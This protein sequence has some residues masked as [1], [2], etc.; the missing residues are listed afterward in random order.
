MRWIG[1]VFLLLIALFTGG[2]SLLMALG[3]VA[4]IRSITDLFLT[5]PI[6]LTPFGVIWLLGV[7]IGVVCMRGMFTIASRTDE[8]EWNAEPS[9]SD[10]R[11][12]QTQVPP[13]DDSIR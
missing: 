9:P 5:I 6:L 10:Q 13:E 11:Q 7:A 8:I 12:S 4:S 2:C 3:M 1:I